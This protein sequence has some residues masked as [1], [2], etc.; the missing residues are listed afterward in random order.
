MQIHAKNLGCVPQKKLQFQVGVFPNCWFLNRHGC[1]CT[2]IIPSIPNRYSAFRVTTGLHRFDASDLPG[3]LASSNL[4]LATFTLNKTEI[5]RS[6]ERPCSGL[7]IRFPTG[8]TPA[9]WR[10][11][12]ALFASPC[13][14]W[15]PYTA[16]SPQSSGGKQMTNSSFFQF[17]VCDC[18]TCRVFCCAPLA[19]KKDI[20]F[21]ICHVKNGWPAANGPRAVVCTPLL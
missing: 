10:S 18:A 21:L 1:T 19:H 16:V 13:F 4:R 2:V 14:T 17:L 7:R 9:G 5:W 3:T 12:D 15:N 11:G 6:P 20:I 8:R